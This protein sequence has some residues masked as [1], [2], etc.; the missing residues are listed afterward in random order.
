MLQEN[1][2]IHRFYCLLS[3]FV[4][5]ILLL[6]VINSTDPGSTSSPGSFQIP[7]KSLIQNS[8]LEGTYSV[9]DTPVKTE[10]KMTKNSE[11]LDD[12]EISK[13]S[14]MINLHLN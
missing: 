13:Q 7:N 2:S 11:P 3:F 6:P 10:P 1:S 4:V 5:I 8:H 9:I 14:I 12:K